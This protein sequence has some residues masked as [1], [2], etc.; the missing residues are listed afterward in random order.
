MPQF[1]GI[2]VAARGRCRVAASRRRRRWHLHLFGGTLTLRSAGKPL[3]YRR[4]LKE[5]SVGLKIESNKVP[6]HILQGPIHPL[7]LYTYGNCQLGVNY[8]KVSL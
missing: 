1:A 7:E 8:S 4:A 5:I 3:T 6:A 2:E